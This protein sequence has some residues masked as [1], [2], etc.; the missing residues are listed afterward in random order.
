M[1]V[2]DSRS[3]GNQFCTYWGK[4]QEEKKGRRGCWA[5]WLE[6]SMLQK[7][8]ISSKIFVTNLQIEVKT[9]EVNE[10]TQAEQRE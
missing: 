9:M 6:L 7:L 4:I 5:G 1:S 10:I 3:Q 2:L 8:K